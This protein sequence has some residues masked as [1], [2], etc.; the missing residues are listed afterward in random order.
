MYLGTDGTSG[1]PDTPSNLPRHRRPP[2]HGG[3]GKDPLWSIQERNLG[4]HLR[5]VADT[6]LVPTHGVIEPTIPMPFAFY[7]QAL[8]ETA[9]SWVRQ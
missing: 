7:Q 3:I 5:Y 6:V 9:P 1:A 4:V 2:E 8:A